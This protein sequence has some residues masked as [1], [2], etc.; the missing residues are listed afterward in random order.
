MNEEMTSDRLVLP[1]ERWAPLLATPPGDLTAADRN[2]LERH[3]ATCTACTFVRA[4]Y[5]HME[6]LIRSLPAPARFSELPP[7]L[8]QALLTPP[9][10]TQPGNFDDV[11]SN[12]QIQ[13]ERLSPMHPTS[14]PPPA[15]STSRRRSVA[16]LVGAVMAAVIVLAFAFTFLARSHV[17]VGNGPG[18]RSSSTPVRTTPPLTST[19]EQAAYLGADGH[20]HEV[21]LNGAHDKTG[22]LLP[23]TDFI[24][25]TDTGWMDAAASP[26]GREIAYVTATSFTTGGDGITIVTVATGAL[27]SVSVPATNIFWSPD[28]SRLAADAYPTGAEGSIATGSIHLINPSTGAVTSINATLDG[29]PADVYRIIGWLDAD[30]LAVIGSRSSGTASLIAPSGQ[31]TLSSTAA[32]LSGG[33]ALQLDVLDVGSRELRH[34]VDLVSPPDVFLSPDG[35]QLFVAPSTWVSTGYVVDPTTSQIR[36]LP[37]ISATFASMFANIGNADFTKGGNW[38]ATMAWKPGTHTIALSLGAWGPGVGEGIGP[39]GPGQSGPSRQA[40][41]VWL[42]DLDHDTAVSVTHNTYPLAWTA[43]GKSLLISNL[44]AS[45]LMYGGL[46]VGP[47]LTT[48]SPASS[49]GTATRLAGHMAVFFGLVQPT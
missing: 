41:G 49:K 42:L 25:Q 18:Q 11:S 26:N 47:T 29:Q 1:C 48:L 43:D 19:S 13:N 35:K 15:I 20:L 40:A 24:S 31:K 39:S 32:E 7:R 4:E 45:S 10:R 3:V 27:R 8:T 37:Q 44:P 38:A 34:L 16:A 5:Q 12:G 23:S 36:D 17:G 33:P 30:H 9:E 6:A 46:S 22:P 14:S 2:A 21:T 28:G